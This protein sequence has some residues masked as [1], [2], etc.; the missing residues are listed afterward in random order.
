MLTD[1]EVDRI[2][3]LNR[4]NQYGITLEE[5]KSLF[6]RH[7]AARKRGDLH[8]METIE[9]R[10]TDINFHHEC[11]LLSSSQYERIIEVIENW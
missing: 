10:L 9:Y 6:K 1:R 2:R 4:K 7:Q 8:E 11:G 5:L 3:A